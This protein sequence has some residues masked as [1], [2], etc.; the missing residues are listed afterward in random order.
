MLLTSHIPL[1]SRLRRSAGVSVL[2]LVGQPLPLPFSNTFRFLF[3]QNRPVINHYNV[4]QSVQNVSVTWTKVA[5][6]DPPQYSQLTAV[7]V[8]FGAA[9]HTAGGLTLLS[10]GAEPSGKVGMEV[11][12]FCIWPDGTQL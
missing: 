6:L 4:V 12:M 9:Q 1:V 8:M 5:S 3:I 7:T 2:P 10:L 11:G